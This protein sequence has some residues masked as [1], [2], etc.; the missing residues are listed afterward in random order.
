MPLRLRVDNSPHSPPKFGKHA[1][2][3]TRGARPVQLRVLQLFVTKYRLIDF[4]C[5]RLA[6]SEV[7]PA[8]PRP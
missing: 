7:S 5:L 1:G 3:Q 8:P 4:L 6:S 2:Q